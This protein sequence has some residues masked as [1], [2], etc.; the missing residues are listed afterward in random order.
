[1][2]GGSFDYLWTADVP[3]LFERHGSLIDIHEAFEEAGV[4]GVAAS[5]EYFRKELVR[6]FNRL[7][8]LRSELEPVWRAMELWKSGDVTEEEFRQTV[9]RFYG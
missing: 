8:K 2:S 1:M 7:E 9:K 4:T 5:T 6:Q 3:E